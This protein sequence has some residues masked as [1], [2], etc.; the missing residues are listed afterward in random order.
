[1]ISEYE[2]LRA[3][4]AERGKAERDS[5][6]SAKSAYRAIVLRR[7]SE[8]GDGVLMLK[9]LDTLASHSSVSTRLPGHDRLHALREVAEPVPPLSDNT[10]AA[11][12]AVLDRIAGIE[13]NIEKLRPEAQ[14]LLANVEEAKRLYDASPTNLERIDER[15]RAKARYDEAYAAYRYGPV[16]KIEKLKADIAAEKMKS[17]A[18]R[19]F[20]A[21]WLTETHTR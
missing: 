13:S 9:A 15:G 4:L 7:F 14:K 6:L 20:D 12:L 10:I 11:D 21:K 16:E 3:A 2:K 18:R 17:D 19:L 5:I 8:D 1:M